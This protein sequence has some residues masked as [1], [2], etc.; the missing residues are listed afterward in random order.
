MFKG[1]LAAS[2]DSPLGAG[3]ICLTRRGPGHYPNSRGTHAA[4]EEADTP[5][6][7]VGPAW[8]PGPVRIARRRGR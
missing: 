1:I 7:G 6:M 4:L 8:G 5:P 2:A 3:P